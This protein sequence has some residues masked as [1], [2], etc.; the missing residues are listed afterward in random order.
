MA[1]FMLVSGMAPFSDALTFRIEE[2]R[3]GEGR[4]AARK[5]GVKGNHLFVCRKIRR[6]EGHPALHA[7][8]TSIRRSAGRD[9]GV[10]PAES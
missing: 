10:T 4:G 8:P 5:I 2:G 9:A 1:Q 3:V 7:P 6:R